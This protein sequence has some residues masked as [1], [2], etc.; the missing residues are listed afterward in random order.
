MIDEEII[1]ERKRA[2]KIFGGAPTAK[3]GDEYAVNCRLSFVK[4]IQFSGLT[5]DVGCGYGAHIREIPD[6]LGLEVQRKFFAIRKSEIVNGIGESIPIRTGSC[7][8]VFLFEVIE[9]VN[10]VKDV[11]LEIRRVI[12][13]DGY[14]FLTA[15]NRFYPF[16]THGLQACG[17]TIENILGIGIPLLSMFPNSIRSRI[18]RARVYSQKDLTELLQQ[19]GFK[20]VRSGYVP[21][22]LD[23]LKQ[24]NLVQAIRSVLQTVSKHAPFKQMGISCLIVAIPT[25]S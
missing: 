17:K 16:E 10:N 19:N 13:P 9:H 14:L 4:D 15:P 12:S 2:S 21:P 1:W 22:N 25:T 18:E 24:S 5:L 3:R 7:G 11:L 8:R 23:T 6:S 20:I